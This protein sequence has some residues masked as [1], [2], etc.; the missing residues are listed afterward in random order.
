MDGP[1]HGGLRTAP[2]LLPPQQIRNAIIAGLSK[3]IEMKEQSL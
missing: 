3:I 2:S 1:A